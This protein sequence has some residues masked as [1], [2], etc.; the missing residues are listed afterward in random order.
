LIG[1]REIRRIGGS[2]R[3]R[4]EGNPVHRTRWIV[5][6]P[7]A[8]LA[9]CGVLSPKLETPKLDVV[10][11]EVMKSDIFQQRLKLRLKV[12]NPND[13]ALPIKGVTT[14]VELA[15]EKFASG[16]SGAEFTVPAF[17]ESE[18]DMIVTAN[19]ASALVRL[20]G[21]KGGKRE[22]IEY[23]VTG[24]VSLATGLLRSI[25]FSETGTFRLQ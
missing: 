14:D 7:L 1:E 10:G 8:L 22:E 9:G 15:G 4:H 3:S 16:V 6:I 20:L 11:I 18:F 5:L 25:P 19:M 21:S 17:G 13:V 2:A 12:Q 24:K 23:R